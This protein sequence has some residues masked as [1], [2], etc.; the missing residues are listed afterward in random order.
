MGK[1]SRVNNAGTF[2][3]ST[4]T[5]ERRRLFQVEA[6][7]YL[8]LTKLQSYQEHFLLHAYVVMPDHVHLILTPRDTS[9]ERV[10]QLLKGGFSHALGSKMPVWQRGFTDHRIRDA[11]DAA[12]HITYIEQ[13]PLGAHLARE[14]WAYP[15]SS[16]HVSRLPLDA[17]PAH[18]LMP[19][20]GLKPHSEQNAYGTAEAVPLRV[21][22]GQ[23][24]GPVMPLRFGAN[25]L[26]VD[27]VRFPQ[28]R[29]EPAQ[30]SAQ[31]E[32]PDLSDC[33]AWLDQGQR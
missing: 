29:S 24:S 19:P 5:W 27:T 8:F 26:A 15:F 14:V 2:F 20:Q 23:L 11:Q 4:Q 31:A 33:A 9:L 6:N 28:G 21:E 10:L 32:T 1:P 13:N 25:R 12:R 16:A 18:L 17:L 7:A 30:A 3:V 22:P